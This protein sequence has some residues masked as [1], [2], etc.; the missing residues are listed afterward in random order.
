[1]LHTADTTI[2]H[3]FYGIAGQEPMLLM[4]KYI[5]SALVDHAQSVCPI[6]RDTV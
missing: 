4:S 3:N 2:L 1:M 5:L 6:K